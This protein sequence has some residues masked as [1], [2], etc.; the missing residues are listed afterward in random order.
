MCDSFSHLCFAVC[1]NL[2]NFLIFFYF[3]FT[4]CSFQ[5]ICCFSFLFI[6]FSNNFANV[7]APLLQLLL[8]RKNQSTFPL[9]FVNRPTSDWFHTIPSSSSESSCIQHFPHFPLRNDDFI[10][11]TKTTLLRFLVSPQTSDVQINFSGNL[12][13][14]TYK[15]F[16]FVFATFFSLI[17]PPS[18]TFTITHASA[19]QSIFFT[20]LTTFT[21][22][23]QIR[24]QLL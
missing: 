10:A 19:V 6:V 17:I 22:T 5:S 4:F 8:M 18:D 7:F 20:S 9:E 16:L 24:P 21:T 3:I 1:P 11:P 23:V 15:R 12:S 2:L 14:T 13:N